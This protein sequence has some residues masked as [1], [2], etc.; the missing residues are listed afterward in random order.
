F[1]ARSAGWPNSSIGYQEYLWHLHVLGQAGFGS[2][3]SAFPSVHVGLVVM[4]A[5][6]LADYNRRLGLAGFAYAVLILASSVYLGWHYAIDGYVAAATV[7]VIHIALKRIEMSRGLFQVRT[8]AVGGP[9][10]AS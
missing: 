3:I 4:N 10:A 9:V 1:L 6:F 5:L 8:A 7:L 2:G